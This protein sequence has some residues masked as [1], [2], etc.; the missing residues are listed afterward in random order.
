MM[1][2]ATIQQWFL[3]NYESWFTFNA[4]EPILFNTPL[5]LGMF[6]IFYPIYI[7]TLKSKTHALRNLY[8]FAFSLFFYYKSSGLYFGLLLVSGITDYNLAKMLHNET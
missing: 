5:F 3:D 2:L 6:L 4:K 7:L 1:D 8:V